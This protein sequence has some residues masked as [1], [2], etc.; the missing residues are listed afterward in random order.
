[1]AHT[2]AAAGQRVRKRHP[3]GG[4]TALGSSPLMATAVFAFSLSGSGSGIVAMSP[5]V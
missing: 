2:S 3:D 5:A 1:M 4:S